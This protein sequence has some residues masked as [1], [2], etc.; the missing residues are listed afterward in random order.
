MILA[1]WR[2]TAEE[3]QAMRQLIAPELTEEQFKT[4]LDQG[5]KFSPA[6]F[7]KLLR[8]L[9]RAENEIKSSVLPQLPL[10]L[11]IVELAGEKP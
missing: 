1:G 6:D 5:Q 11:V 3:R 8:L 10:E 2:G 9:I 7:I 4:I